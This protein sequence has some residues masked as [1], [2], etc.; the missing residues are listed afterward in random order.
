MKSRSRKPVKEALE[1][2]DKKLSRL[3]E[4]L[5]AELK[6]MNEIKPE[7]AAEN[8]EPSKINIPETRKRKP[9]LKPKQP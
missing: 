6:V 3:I 5:N 4:K 8:H 7:M 1:S 2:S 9:N